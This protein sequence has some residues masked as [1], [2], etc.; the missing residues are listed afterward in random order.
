[1]YDEHYGLSGRPF[2]LTPDPRFW[3]ESATHRK[4]MAYLGYGLSQGEGFIVVTGDIGAGKT[5]LVGHLMATIDRERLHAIKIVSTQIE[6]DDLLRL[7][8]T[9]LEI[10]TAGLPKAQLLERIERAL[11][12][13]ARSGRRTLLIVDEA[14]A[15]PVASLEELRMLS[16]F[17]AGG[18]ALLQIFL[19]G[20]PEFRERLYGNDRLEQL[21]Q[22]VIATHHLEPMAPDEIEPYMRHRL[23][24][25]GWSDR[26][27]FTA[28]A[29]AALYAGSGGVPR[30]L[31]QLAGRVMLY[32]AIEG[33]AVID[34]AAVETVIADLAGDAA[35]VPVQ[36]APAPAPAPVAPSEPAPASLGEPDW[37]EPAAPMP[38]KADWFEI[39]PTPLPQP[40]SRTA[41]AVE[42]EAVVA[43]KAVV[44]PA[45]IEP[46]PPEPAPVPAPVAP[47]SLGDPDWFDAPAPL[48][49]RRAPEPVADAEPTPLVPAPTPEPEP[50]SEPRIDPTL[51]ARI[52]AL[53]A[54]TDEQD[55]ALRRILTLLIDW[56]EGDSQRPDIS[57]LRG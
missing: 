3:F 13:V 20:Q 6:A 41:P 10:D 42:P 46:P 56:I 37:F 15:L 9:G 34:G 57:S 54:R 48:P 49:L 47:P 29:F 5:T 25:V 50:E 19:L 43:P 28:D 35:A 36:P 39:D 45:P 17:Q 32:G 24:L 23:K 40:P 4:A 14:Q 26:P 31:N 38:A 12:A 51:A 2:Q 52:A 8:A 7:V 44:E 18:H 53:E 16:N 30:R 1:M 22:R 55:A 27:R 11:H 33:L 21:R